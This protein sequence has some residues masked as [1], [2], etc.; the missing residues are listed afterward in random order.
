MR[1]ISGHVVYALQEG[2][3][4]PAL[5]TTAA[6]LHHKGIASLSINTGHVPLHCMS[7]HTL[8]PYTVSGL[9]PFPSA[10][11]NKGAACLHEVYAG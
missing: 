7:P 2:T 9:H 4:I 5:T 6:A 1:S 8:Q 11:L 3:D 10:L